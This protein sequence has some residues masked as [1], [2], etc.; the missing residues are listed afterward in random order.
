MAYIT[1][2]HVG[3]KAILSAFFLCQPY[4]NITFTSL[5]PFMLSNVRVEDIVGLGT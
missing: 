4:N 1:V 2:L 5:L 3:V